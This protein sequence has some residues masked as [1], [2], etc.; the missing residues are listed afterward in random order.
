MAATSPTASG[1]LAS[2]PLATLLVYAL[3]KELGGS[4]VFEAP[5]GGRSAVFVQQGV[6]GKAK[7][8]VPVIHLG[9]L[10]L[11]MSAI[12]EVML[13][14]TLARCAKER[15]P[16]GQILLG[17]GV[18]DETTLKDALAEQLMRKVVWLFQLPAS[19]IYAFYEGKNFLG[20]Y[21]PKELTSIEPLATIWR[22]VRAHERSDRLG[23]FAKQMGRRRLALHR[24]AQ[25][26]RFCFSTREWAALDLL[27]VRPHT[28]GEL[29]QAGVGSEDMIL[30]LIYALAITRHLDVGQTPCG[31][32]VV[33]SQAPRAAMNTIPED[34]IPPRQAVSKPA[35]ADG[36]PKLNPPASVAPSSSA[37]V[38]Q[39]KAP[40]PL[41][42]SATATPI[43]LTTSNVTLEAKR[44][45]VLLV[46]EQARKQNYYEILG[47]EPKAKPSDISKAYFALAKQWHPDRL[48]PEHEE[49]REV[50]SN[51]FSTMSEAHQVLTEPTRRSEYDAILK[52]GGG[53]AE[54][55]EQ[56][57]KVMRAVTEFQKADILFKRN[58]IPEA[59]LHAQRAM[60]NDPGQAEYVALWVAIAMVKRP[61]EASVED[62]LEQIQAALKNEPENQRARLVRGRLYKRLGKAEDAFKDFR[63]VAE[64]DPR[65]VDAVREVRL[66]R[67]RREKGEK[68]KLF[69]K[70]FKR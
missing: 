26:S 28:L 69:G 48:A 13:N 56:V 36:R 9:R 58:K 35:P 12:D 3:D 27:R 32:E 54:D 39:P 46:S 38:V 31:V 50:V 53:K 29:A 23:A 63:W 42:E 47:V 14:R 18:V 70:W 1:K 57:Q 64:R 21:G 68:G 40:P 19:T 44:A 22:G 16:H 65:N 30:R 10:L 4:F 2:T 33:L 60:E 62:L 15:V 7:T 25:L 45:E 66:F 11:E 8:A 6:V 49:L 59:E 41:A 67:M 43:A 17:E 34:V 52:E 55:Q 51:V 20:N 61:A 37:Q 24:H 5:E